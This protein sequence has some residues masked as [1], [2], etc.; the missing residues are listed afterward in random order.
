M[1]FVQIGDQLGDTPVKGEQHQDVP[2]TEDESELETEPNLEE[3]NLI[4][5]L[6]KQ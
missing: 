2:P 3:K 5:P 6:T 1:E 4:Y